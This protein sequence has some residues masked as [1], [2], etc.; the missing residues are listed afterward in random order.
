MNNNN[1]KS[2]VTISM[3]NPI[4]DFQTLFI[5]YPIESIE[6]LWH[7]IITSV[8]NKMSNTVISSTIIESI[9]IIRSKAIEL[10]NSNLFNSK[11]ILIK[12]IWNV[13]QEQLIYPI[14][15]NEIN[16]SQFKNEDEAK[17]FYNNENIISNEID[18]TFNQTN[19]ETNDLFDDLE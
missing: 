3:H 8:E 7:I 1:N 5:D 19:N 9:K 10:N 2:L 15:Q 18:L 16:D 14:N 11:L 4:N 13:L 12:S 6:Q 17:Q